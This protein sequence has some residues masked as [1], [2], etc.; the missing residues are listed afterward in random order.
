MSSVDER[1][2]EL[3]FNNGQFEA[4]VNQSVESLE[5]LKKGLDLE[6]SAKSL[7]GLKSAGRSFSLTNVADN[8][9]TVADRFS[10]LGIIGDEAL[11]RITN[12]AINLGKNLLTAI[13]NQI[14][15][16]GKRRAQNLEQAKF[17]LE[18][19]GIAWDQ[20]SDSISDAVQDTAYGLDAAAVAASQYA[21]SGVQLGEDMTKALRAISGVAAMTNSSYE[22]TARVFTAVAGQGKL[23]TMQMNQLAIRGLNVAATLANAMG[24]T[25]A[26]IREMVT[27]GKIDFQTFA[28]IMDDTF[29]S[30]AKEA[31]KTFSGALSNLKASL[32][33]MGAKFATPA[34]E[35]LR[36]AIVALTPVLKDI[37]K[38]I[39]P[40]AAA[41]TKLAEAASAAS[42]D[43]FKSAIWVLDAGLGKTA[44]ETQKTID[45]IDE[46]IKKESDS[47]EKSAAT[48]AAAAK[49]AEKNNETLTEAKNAYEEVALSADL[50][51]QTMAD[52]ALGL[53]SVAKAH[54]EADKGI[55]ATDRI[56]K[57]ATKN[58]EAFVV[59]I[60]KR[61]A[62][63]GEVLG[64]HKK[65]KK[66][67]DENATAE[68]KLAALAKEVILGKFGNGEERKNAIEGLGASYAIVQNKVNELLG[69]EKRH[70]VTAED[71][72]KM[73]EYLGETLDGTGEKAE[74]SVTPFDKLVNILA[75]LRAAFEIVTNAG[76]A[77]WNHIL[78]PFLKWAG[79]NVL[80]L[81]TTALSGIGTRLVGLNQT[82]VSGDFFNTKFKA[83]ADGFRE[84][85]G[86]VGS[87]VDKVKNLESVKKVS[88]S[89]GKLKTSAKA[90]WDQGLA[91]V[92]GGFTKMKKD[93]ED[94]TFGSWF[95]EVIDNI[96]NKLS[97][98]LDALST[99]K[100]GAKEFGKNMGEFFSNLF[101]P[102][103]GEQVEN[104]LVG[105]FSNFKT[106][107]LDLF[108]KAKG[109]AGEFLEGFKEGVK[110]LDFSQIFS[111][112]KV[113]GLI[114]L[115][116]A[117]IGALPVTLAGL[118]VVTL[119]GGAF[120]NLGEKFESFKNKIKDLDGIKRLTELFEKLKS[121][122]KPLTDFIRSKF[123]NAIDKLMPIFSGDAT[124]S[125]VLAVVIDNVSGKLA[126]FLGL[127]LSAKDAVFNFFSS[128]TDGSVSI[129]NLGTPLD[130]VK[131]K[132][133]GILGGEGEGAENPLAGFIAN[134]P[135]WGAELFAKAQTLAGSFFDGFKAGIG[136]VNFER[137][138]G[139][140]KIASI[141]GI[142]IA[143]MKFLK[144][145]GLFK[146]IGKLA[147][148]GIDTFRGLGGALL[149]WQRTMKADAFM[150]I[151]KAIAALV[152]SVVVLTMLDPNDLGRAIG[153]IITL[154]GVLA[155]LIAVYNI[156]ARMKTGTAAVDPISAF[157]TNLK[158][159]LQKS[160]RMAGFGIAL[161]GIAIA[162]GILQSIVNKF[163]NMKVGK[164]I[165]GVIFTGV[166]F[167]LLFTFCKLMK[168]FDAE[169]DI[170][171]GASLFLIAESIKVLAKVVKMLGKLDVPTLA[172]GIVAVGA[173]LTM[174]AIFGK[175][176]GD[177]GGALMKLSTAMLVMAIALTALY[178][179]LRL[180]GGLDIVT[181]GYSLFTL[182]A[183]IATVLGI[184]WV[185]G[186]VE[187]GLTAL[188]NS[189]LKIGIA[190]ALV[191]ISL[192]LIAAGLE[193]FV[194]SL[195]A[196]GEAVLGNIKS[197]VVGLIAFV[198]VMG[199]IVVLGYFANG[200]VMGLLAIAAVIAAIGVVA[201]GFAAGLNAI[202]GACDAIPG[203]S[204]IINGFVDSLGASFTGLGDVIYSI[205]G[206]GGAIG[207][208]L[209]VTESSVR[210]FEKTLD[211]LGIDGE[212]KQ[213]LVTMMKELTD[214]SG[215]DFSVKLG[216]LKAEIEKLDIPDEKKQQLLHDTFVNIRDDAQDHLVV[217][218]DEV[219][220]QIRKLNI[221]ESEKMSL[222]EKIK[223]LANMS[224][225][226][227]TVALEDL[228]IYCNDIGM[229]PETV[230]KIMN[231]AQQVIDE[232]ADAKTAT[233]ELLKIQ[234]DNVITDED[235]KKKY[236]EAIEKMKGLTGEELQVEI[237]KFVVDVQNE[238]D[239]TPASK[240][241]L[242]NLAKSMSDVV[243]S[244]YTENLDRRIKEYKAPPIYENK[245]T[246]V[247]VGAA[248]MLEKM[249][250][251]NDGDMDKIV[252]QLKQK[253]KFDN[254]DGSVA[255][256][257]ID[258]IVGTSY[259]SDQLMDM[260]FPSGE[261]DESAFREMM[262]GVG[263]N[264][265]EGLA[266]GINGNADAPKEAGEQT[267]NS[268]LEAFTGI[269][270]INSPSKVTK[271]YGEY[272]DVGLA[273]GITG[274]AATVR[275]AATLMATM[276]ILAI[277]KKLQ[278]FKAAGT[279]AALAF[280]GGI[281]SKGKTAKSAGA[282]LSGDA[283]SGLKEHVD[284]AYRLGQDFGEGFVRGIKSK[285]SA[286]KAAAKNMTSEAVDDAATGQA[287]ASPSKKTM[288]LGQYF[289]EGY[290][291]GITSMGRKVSA[292]A[293]DM[294][295][296]AVSA[297]RSPMEAIR[298]V[299]NSDLD[300]DPVIRPVLDLSDIQNGARTIN[301]LLPAGSMSLGYISNSMNAMAARDSDA[302]LISA[303][304]GLG[305]NMNTK[306]GD[307][308][309]ID[310]ITYDDGSNVSD[311]VRSLV[312]AARMERRR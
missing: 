166:L 77:L 126:T 276:A 85:G 202:A 278:A 250:Q 165:K 7:D 231:Y 199:S 142:A 188:S 273:Q 60:S 243:A 118:A 44:E 40:A 265:D 86:R 49:E 121:K 268:T 178:I 251:V 183:A 312:R 150:T 280:I 16:G 228:R 309:V 120:S 288:K 294:S 248:S 263:F 46:S 57:S 221:S 175:H 113:G 25:E 24:V 94:S 29:G 91:K 23:M 127:L 75:G 78:S 311:A 185:A 135:T 230:E 48:T 122:L 58:A 193:A 264:V 19:L 39:D 235:A 131:S 242:I 147:G 206:I 80:G 74:E 66:A 144:V 245:D 195:I 54:A 272:L 143:L 176:S 111:W 110:N 137:L 236:D 308:Y 14:I 190:A 123:K 271:G 5:R 28:A 240:N 1:V 220:L 256:D 155:A 153:A 260:I 109:L 186:H 34:Y 18:G 11:R 65:E 258:S 26:E 67:L 45:D 134:I 237:D 285:A 216:E 84:V 169:V 102:K 292:V 180:F 106:W 164:A 55:S 96:L 22:D 293:K 296:E 56:Y 68:E 61:I 213:K 171:T 156:T 298:N 149:N 244:A 33:R 297:L 71:E 162:V 132:I 203:L 8:V 214:L 20:V 30:H 289:G 262:S 179:P 161:A 200:A 124:F 211:G 229:Y 207:R 41:F 239:L 163:A 76:K 212:T 115:A 9:Q 254:A 208:L 167:G 219:E 233:I 116:V 295:S 282:I 83:I 194:A 99:I 196:I 43:L 261:F 37:E 4:G 90:L 79:T 283:S 279:T 224:E 158:V 170:K 197:A 69:V 108:N 10:T 98:F 232:S 100:D 249:F 92:T 223:A 73:A 6:A 198:A 82:I 182:A 266:E 192:P 247:G 47:T 103:E 105:F 201:L 246:E 42:V 172:K 125:D 189:L 225:E 222:L 307:T 101:K 160:L 97:E 304:E 300:V 157:L 136:E 2:V 52:G 275:T 269:F 259:T 107:G 95:L 129:E 32:S 184:A 114:A 15:S 252:K 31:N 3:Q 205:P 310:G 204:G 62:P 305:K 89:F 148:A 133:K 306:G 187:K 174:F 301:G 302:D 267:A 277:S 70:E 299:L 173:L 140:L 168:K 241:S 87:F 59:G 284:D 257:V 255:K 177:N 112:L 291:I 209:G 63:L 290:I 12:S 217:V 27:K 238:A 286:A 227:R 119:L 146:T 191:G 88:E 139:G 287:S 128:L 152:G 270:Q 159:A 51:G 154:A 151:A 72:A 50:F 141:I 17:Q 218:L 64:L 21:A 303:I 104:P 226:E 53:K 274:K 210:E 117:G 138:L 145:F 13:P 81:I 234:V 215:E 130:T 181:L 253:L 38:Y 36:K 93:F 281:S 35:E